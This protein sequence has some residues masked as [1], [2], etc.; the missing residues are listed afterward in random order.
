MAMTANT[1]IFYSTINQ[2]AL[3]QRLYFLKT[4]RHLSLSASIVWTEPKREKRRGRREKMKTIGVRVHIR[5]TLK[6]YYQT[7]WSARSAAA[8]IYDKPRP[9]NQC[10]ETRVY[11]GWF[12][13]LPLYPK[14]SLLLFYPADLYASKKAKPDTGSRIQRQEC[15]LYRNVGVSTCVCAVWPLPSPHNEAAVFCQESVI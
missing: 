2:A 11:T 13:L 3:D 15:C 10:A 4:H 12:T 14:K 7:D 1:K 9:W 6:F 8:W 5:Q